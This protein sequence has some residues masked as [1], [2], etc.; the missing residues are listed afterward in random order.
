MKREYFEERIFKTKE[1]CQTF[2]SVRLFTLQRVR[3]KFS[4]YSTHNREI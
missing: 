4:T 2:V 3:L 1:L